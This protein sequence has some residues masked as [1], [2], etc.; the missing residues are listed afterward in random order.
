HDGWLTEHGTGGCVSIQISCDQVLNHVG[1]CF[2]GKGNYIQNLGKNLVALEESMEDLMA[3]REDLLQKVQIA[4]DGGLLRLHQIK[5]WLTRVVTI[6][7]QFK[8]LKNVGSVELQRR[9]KISNVEV[10]FEVV[11]QPI[12]PVLVEERPIQP[13]IVGHEAMLKKAWRYLMDDEVR[14]MGLYGMGGVGKTTLLTQINNRFC[15]S[16]YEVDII[17]W[18]VVSSDLQICKIQEEVGDKIGFKGVEWNR[19]RQNQKAVDILNFL[20]RKRFVLLLDDIWR[21]VE[22]FEIGIPNPTRENKKQSSIYHSVYR[23]M[24]EMEVQCLTTNDAWDLFQKKVGQTTL[25]S[26]PD[27]LKIAI[28]VAEK[29]CGLP[30]ALNVIGETMACKRTTQEWNHAYSYD[31]LHGEQVKSCFLYCSLL[32]E[33]CQIYKE[34]L[35][36][37]WIGEGFIDEKEGRERALNQGYE[38]IGTLVR[39]CLLLEEGSNKSFVKMHD[40]IREMTL[41]I[42]SDLGKNKEICIVQ[43]GISLCEVPKVKEWRTVER[44]S[45]MNN[46]IEDISGSPDCPELRTLFFQK[47]GLSNISSDFFRFMPRLVV[48]DLSRNPRLCNLPEQ[49][50]ELERLPIGLYELTTIIRLNLEWMRRLES[51]SGIS[52]LSNI[53]L[54]KELELL[55]HL[56]VLTVDIRSSLVVEQLI[57]SPRLM[58]CIQME[59][60]I[61]WTTSSWNRSSTTPCFSNL[62]KVIMKYCDG[63]KDLTWLL[64]APN[65]TYLVVD[66]SEQVEDII[67][68]EKFLSSSIIIIPFMKLEYLHLSHLPKLMSIYRRPLP[69]PCLREIQVNNCPKLRKIPLDSNSGVASKELVIKFVEKEWM[70]R[71]E[72]EDE[73]TKQHFLPMSQE[74]NW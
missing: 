30:L 12:K 44:M 7:N 21:K 46:E 25:A 60:E 48:L 50:S 34:G 11:A 33:D 6:E 17:I 43:A 15:D 23:R 66:N 70:E 39:A 59:I 8:D 69:F 73:A 56:E 57:N 16:N 72:W 62:G 71:I 49:I 37:Y 4:E 2:C 68:E 24:C 53:N 31:N 40:V 61:D 65:L 51:I 41:W 18:V 28:K 32:P 36:E 10:F 54:M 58:R 42:T 47:S 26:H 3:M 1:S 29:C 13:T 9:L 5:V 38:I 52:N 67:T 55:E 64:F 74:A 14:I 19:K 22:L 20:K 63:L 45:L 35:I 27:I